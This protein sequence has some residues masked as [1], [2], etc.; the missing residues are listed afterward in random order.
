M[1]IIRHH[2]TSGYLGSQFNGK[3][4][5]VGG[6]LFHSQVLLHVRACVYTVTHAHTHSLKLLKICLN[7]I[8]FHVC[9]NIENS[10]FAQNF[11]EDQY[12]E[13]CPNIYSV[14]PHT[15][16]HRNKVYVP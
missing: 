16:Q 12:S 14:P 9:V 8:A 4:L 13:K 6:K 7:S 3:A 5:L 10:I 2:S 1:G 15:P 11:K